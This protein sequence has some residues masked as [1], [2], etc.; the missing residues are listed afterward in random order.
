M[1]WAPGSGIECIDNIRQQRGWEVPALIITGHDIEKIHAALHDRNIAILSKPV[2]PVELRATLRAL[3]E[4]PV[5]LVH[6]VGA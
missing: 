2:R 5:A 6:Q 4:T 3:R 1:T